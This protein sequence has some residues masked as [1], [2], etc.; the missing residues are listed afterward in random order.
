MEITNL[1]LTE[2]QKG[3]MILGELKL[4]KDDTP[5]VKALTMSIVSRVG[6]ALKKMRNE[7]E[8]YGEQ[9][10]ELVTK[11]AKKDRD[12][13]PIPVLDD[14]GRKTG[15]ELDNVY[16][17][18]MEHRALLKV[19]VNVSDDIKKIKVSELLKIGYELDGNVAG[20]L[21]DFLEHDLPL[22]VTNAN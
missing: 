10:N 1:E 5:E 9:H 20:M 4:K 3:L 7:I 14:K 16:L 22:E 6:I 2:N 21:G 17:F 13:N 12:N 11:H 8:Q 15:I 19:K 18:N